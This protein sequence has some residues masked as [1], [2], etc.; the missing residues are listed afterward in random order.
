MY[1]NMK[2][3]ATACNNV[4]ECQDGSDEN[5]SDS[6]LSNLAAAAPIAILVIYLGLKISRLMCSKCWKTK[7]NPDSFDQKAIFKNI[8]NYHNDPKAILNLNNYLLHTI[9][10]QKINKTKEICKIYYAL[11]EAV[12]CQNYSEILCCLY[13]RLD[14]IVIEEVLDAEEPGMMTQF[15]KWLGKK[16]KTNKITTL[17]N[18]MIQKDWLNHFLSS[19]IA[20]YKIESGALDILKDFFLAMLIMNI[21][22][23]PKAIWEFQ[24][25]FSSIVAMVAFVIVTVPIILS[26][27]HLMIVDPWAILSS[28]KRKRIPRIFMM[29]ICI[30]LFGITPILLLHAFQSIEEDAIMSSKKMKK[31]TS[32]LFRQYHA[33]RRHCVE[34]LKIELGMEIFYQVPLQ[35]TL[36]LLAIT[37]TPT[38]G[39][40]ETLFK[41]DSVFSIPVDPKTALGL[42][43][44]K[45]I[46]SCVNLHLKTIVVQKVFVPFTSKMFIWTWG[47]FSTLR[48]ILSIVAFFIPFFGLFN[49][50]NHWKAEQIPFW[51]RYDI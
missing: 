45:S 7:K 30:F 33:A 10:A 28:K 9:H 6:S 50:L 38:T 29:I 49:V 34:H 51:I 48:R 26:S 44:A 24:S 22:G 15:L 4:Q 14:P 2:T 17:Q 31:S 42:S 32:K 12:H 5:C 36:L 3:I 18:K 47:L 27:F 1:P 39:G 37:T 11:E 23:G 41:R 46:F 43:V 13:Q 19:L 21:V 8:R 40:L 25:N 20:I 16:M 35:V